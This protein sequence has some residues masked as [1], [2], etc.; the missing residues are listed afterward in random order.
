MMFEIFVFTFGF[1]MVFILGFISGVVFHDRVLV[2][3]PKHPTPVEKVV[4]KLDTIA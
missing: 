4:G 3:P 1:L 2:I